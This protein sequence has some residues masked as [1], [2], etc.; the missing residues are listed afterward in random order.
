MQRETGGSVV[1][2]VYHIHNLKTTGKS[3]TTG[4]KVTLNL[5]I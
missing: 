3:K 1:G 5:E 2:S 4:T